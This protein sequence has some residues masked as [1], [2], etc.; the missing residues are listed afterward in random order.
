MD[1]DLIFFR[2]T[3]LGSES[4]YIYVRSQNCQNLKL[5]KNNL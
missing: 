1:W 3:K 4:V 5:L 2:L